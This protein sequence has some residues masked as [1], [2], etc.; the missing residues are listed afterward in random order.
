MP[1]LTS[2]SRKANR[3]LNLQEFAAGST[4]LLSRP[5]V[6]FVELTENCNLSCPMCRSGGA[7]DRSKNMSVELFDH[8]AEELFPTA[9]IV[10]LRGWGESTVLRNFPEYVDKTLAYG[11]RVRLVTNLTVPNERLWRHLVRNRSLITVSFDAAEEATFAAL[12]TGAK[13]RTILRNLEILADEARVS[14][15][16]TDGINLNVVVQAAAL[17]ELDR[18]IEI[19]GGLGF[20]VHLAPVTLGSDDPGNLRF[21]RERLARAVRKAAAVAEE[22]GA[23]VRLAAALDEGWAVSEHAGKTCTHPWMYC[24]VNHTGKVGFCD[25][26]IGAPGSAYLLGDLTTTPFEQIWNGDAYQRLRAEHAA[27]ERGISPRFEECNWCYRNRYVD[28]DE[29]SNPDYAQ[30]IVRLTAASCPAGVPRSD[31]GPGLPA[32]APPAALL[33]IAD[34][35]SRAAHPE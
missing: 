32:G 10:D 20:R 2:A 33:P 6:L 4:S 1:E 29:E 28:F 31:P 12:R 19:A 17:D 30:H 23:D 21:H 27:W 35:T 8:I 26:L 25:H 5:R 11:C 22:T 3:E 7:F 34:V 16:G 18:I 15:V 14:G 13:L 24:Y 9:E